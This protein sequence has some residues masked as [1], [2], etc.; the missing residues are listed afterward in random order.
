MCMYVNILQNIGR[1]VSVKDSEI[2]QLS[3]NMRDTERK[4]EELRI[5]KVGCTV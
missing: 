2:Q 5:Q 1:N 4:E 3:T